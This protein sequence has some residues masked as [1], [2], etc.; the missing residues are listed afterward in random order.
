MTAIIHPDSSSTWQICVQSHAGI[1]VVGTR[2]FKI[3]EKQRQE[4]RVELPTLEV[5]GLDRDTAEIRC[6]EWNL[7]L[8]VQSQLRSRAG[9]AGE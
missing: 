4:N 5:R 6:R 7:F 2:L 1:N 8:K 3:T 9:I